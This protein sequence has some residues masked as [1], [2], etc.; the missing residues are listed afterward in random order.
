MVFKVAD[1]AA[2]KKQTVELKPSAIA[3]GKEHAKWDS[4]DSFSVEGTSTAT[5]FK[6]ECLSFKEFGQVSYTWTI[7]L[8]GLPTYSWEKGKPVADLI[9]PGTKTCEQLGAAVEKAHRVVVQ[10]K[11]DERLGVFS[12]YLEDLAKASYRPLKEVRQEYRK[13]YATEDEKFLPLKKKDV[14]FVVTNP[15]VVRVVHRT[16][17][18]VIESEPKM[19]PKWK[20]KTRVS[21]PLH[22]A[23]VDGK[24]IVCGPP[25]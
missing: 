23:Y 9:K 16:R 18:N 10:H 25:L 2:G 8:K 17:K 22:F 7:E 24:W 14:G 19:D 3:S 4:F 20:V 21:R 12:H 13:I 11:V 6:V 1:I 15:R 5:R